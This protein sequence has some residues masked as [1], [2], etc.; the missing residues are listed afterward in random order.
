MFYS[1]LIEIENL[2]SVYNRFPYA[3]VGT[4]TGK[5]P[6]TVASRMEK[7]P[8][9]SL[10]LP[11][12]T[13]YQLNAWYSHTQQKCLIFSFR[14]ASKSM[15]DSI[16]VVS[17]ILIDSHLTFHLISFSA[18]Y[19]FPTQVDC[20][21]VHYHWALK[22]CVRSASA[23]TSSGDKWYADWTSGDDICKND[24]GA[25]DYS[26]FLMNMILFRPTLFSYKCMFRVLQ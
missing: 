17:Q 10:S 19:L 6:M 18:V 14:H 1:D 12:L 15:Y 25:P 7:N 23:S 13:F 21:K 22:D 20:C 24:G 4:L 16:V 3:M 2:V 9:V 8:T 11:D 5:D 26:E